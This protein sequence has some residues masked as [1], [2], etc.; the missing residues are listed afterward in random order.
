M[1]WPSLDDYTE[2]CRIG[3]KMSKYVFFLFLKDFQIA[4]GNRAER[5]IKI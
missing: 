4:V 3:R 5:E 2:E 1:Q